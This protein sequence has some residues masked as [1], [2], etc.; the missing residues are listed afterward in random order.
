MNHTR[1]LVEI[2]LLVA[3]AYVLDLFAGVYSRLFWPQ[4]GSVS[5]ALIPMAI[6]A[7]R[8]GIKLGMLGGLALGILQLIVGAYIVHPIQ[9]L[10][11]FLLPY[12]GA[13][14]IIG[15]WSKKMAVG[16]PRR[17]A[18]I[19]VSLFFASAF[20]FASHWV[21]G[22][23]FFYMFAPEGMNTWVY[24]F[25][26]NFPQQ[27]FNWLLAGTLLAIMVKR[28]DFINASAVLG[29]GKPALEGEF[30]V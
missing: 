25:V 13:C 22:I 4:G 24:S 6:I 2:S 28:Y 12:I 5:A 17:N 7:Y 21:S 16:H 8:H 11:D 26:Y 9:V 1:T 27:F 19:W 30:K 20:R 3:L 29:N 10:L 18:R 15:M 14:A 23:V